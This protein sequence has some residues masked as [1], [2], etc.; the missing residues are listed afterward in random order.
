LPAATLPA[1]AAVTAAQRQELRR[2]SAAYLHEAMTR[3]KIRD[4]NHVK[5]GVGEATRVLLRRVPDLV[6][7]RDPALP[8]VA[9]LRH[10]AAEKNVPILVD[11]ALPYLAAALIKEFGE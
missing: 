2:Q 6:L 8:D 1:A 11:G 9:H 5:P 10:L 3:F 4:V 7:L